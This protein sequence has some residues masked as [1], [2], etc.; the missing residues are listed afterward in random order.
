MDIC[1]GLRFCHSGCNNEFDGEI[2]LHRDLNPDNVLIRRRP[3]IEAALGDFG[4]SRLYPPG[5]VEPVG[6]TVIGTPGSV[7]LSLGDF[8]PLANVAAGARIR[9]ALGASS[10]FSA[11]PWSA[12]LS[13]MTA[14]SLL[15]W[16][17]V[18]GPGDLQQW[19]TEPR[20]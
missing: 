20:Q 2:I 8:H 19:F 3:H 15:A 17:Q 14:C 5:G 16:W 11:T 10:L 1:D 9:H 12:C 6:S 7:H 13:S 18:P 4:L